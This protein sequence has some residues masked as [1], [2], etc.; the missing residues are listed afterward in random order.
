MAPGLGPKCLPGQPVPSQAG[1]GHCGTSTPPACQTD[2]ESSPV[3]RAG[4]GLGPVM[5]WHLDFPGHSQQ[6]PPSQHP[7]VGLL[8]R[9]GAPSSGPMAMTPQPTAQALD[10][11]C[12]Q[13]AKACDSDPVL[14]GTPLPWACVPVTCPLPVCGLERAALGTRTWRV[15]QRGQCPGGGGR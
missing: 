9:G 5:G 4:G 11:I 7:S 1:S 10:K 12:L 14:L 13:K 8:R 3:P 2:Q 6:G 15:A